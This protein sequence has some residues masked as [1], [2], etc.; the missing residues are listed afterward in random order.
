[1][2]WLK[3]YSTPHLCARYL[4]LFCALGFVLLP[5]SYVWANPAGEQVVGGAATFQ[6][7]GNKLTVNQATDRLAV[8]WQSFNIGAGESTH[9]NMPSSTSAALNRVIGGNPSSIYGSLSANGI[10]YLINPSGI[11]VGPGGTVNAASFMASTLDVSTEQFMNAKNG[12]GMN[13]YGSSGESIIN[14]GNITAEKGDVFLVAQKVENRGTINAA[15][16]TAGIVGSGQNTDVMVHEV[17]GKGFA[18]RVAQLQGE[19]ATGSN[20]DL[21]DGEELLNE[22]SINAAQAELNASG[23]VYALAIRNSGTIRAKAVVANADGTVRLDGGLGDVINTGKMYAKNAGND[24]TA[25]GGRID[26]AGQNVTASPESIITAAGGEKGGNGGSVKIDSQDTTLVQ[27]RVDVAAPSAGAKGGKVQLLGERVGLLDGAKVDAS[28]GAGGGTV[29]VGGDYLGGQTPSADLKNLAKQEAEPVKNAKATVMADTAEIKADATV[30]G[31]GGKIVLWSDEY[32]G[33][34]GDLFARGGVEGGNGGFIETSSKNNLQAMGAG[35]ASAAN[36]TGGL[37]LLDPSNLVISSLASSGGSFNSGNPNVFTPDGTVNTAVVNNGTIQNSLNA[38]TDVTLLTSGAATGTGDITMTAGISKDA[39]VSGTASTLTMIAAGSIVISQAISSVDGDLP[40]VLGAQSGVTIGAN[41]TTLGGNLTVRGATADGASLAASTTTVTMNSGTVSTLGGDGLGN[42]SITATGPVNQKG[43]TLLIKGTSSITTGGAA[44]T[45][46]QTANDFTGS[47]SLN[48]TGAN[49]VAV[50]DANTLTLGNSTIGG[51][52]GVVT[53][54]GLVAGGLNQ[55]GILTIAGISTI[56]SSVAST[57]IDLSTQANLLTGTVVIGGTASNVRDFKLRN[58]S[59]T[60]SAVTN[61][62]N[63]TTTS[64]RDFTIFYD[65]AS[66]AIP[67]LVSVLTLRNISI[68]ANGGNITQAGGIL[69]TGTATFSTSGASG[70]NID[71]SN[72]SNDFQGTVNATASNTAKNISI[73]DINDLQLGQIVLG[74]GAGNLS[75]TFGQ[76]TDTNAGLTMSETGRIQM[77]G[78]TGQLLLTPT[79]SYTDILLGVLTANANSIAVAASGITI[80]NPGNVRDLNIRNV[81]GSANFASS[82]A[83]VLPATY[84]PNLRDISLNLPNSSF[85]IPALAQSSLRNINVF[86]NGITTGAITSPNGLINLYSVGNFTITGNVNTLSGD[87]GLKSDANLTIND[88]I[89]IGASTTGN[90][91]LFADADASGAGTLSIGNTNGTGTIIGNGANNGTYRIQA[92]TLVLGAGAGANASIV[93]GSG[94]VIFAA[95]E[96]SVDIGL[97]NVVPTFNV[98]QLALNRVFSPGTVQLGDE[99]QLGNILLGSLSL[100]ANTFKTLSLVTSGAGSALLPSAGSISLRSFGINFD[101]NTNVD[102]SNSSLILD[103]TSAGFYPTGANVS[104]LK[105]VDSD[106]T[107]ATSGGELSITAG[108]AGDVVFQRSVGGINPLAV[109]SVIQ[110]NTV[111]LSRVTSRTTGL[112]GDG[113]L[114]SI[115]GDTIKLGGSI[116]LTGVTAGPGVGDAGGQLFVSGN[117]VTVN[118]TFN[119][120]GGDGVAPLTGSGNFPGGPSGEIQI[121]ALDSILVLKDP[122]ATIRGNFIALGGNPSG[123]NAGFG[124]D[125][126]V[127][128][129]SLKDIIFTTDQTASRQMEYQITAGRNLLF[130]A[131]G[132]QAGAYDPTRPLNLSGLAGGVNFI[133]NIDNTDVVRTD[134]EFNFSGRV[135]DGILYMAAGSSIRTNGGQLSI[136]DNKK[137]DVQIT[138]ANVDVTNSSYFGFGYSGTNDLY[139]SGQISGNSSDGS[140]GAVISILAAGANL[141]IDGGVIANAT[142][143]GSGGTIKIVA[144]NLETPQISANGSETITIGTTIVSPGL[145]GIVNI[146]TSG[147]SIDVQQILAKGGSTAS[148]NYTLG[149]NGGKITI[150]D[151]SSASNFDIVRVD[152]GGGD[153]TNGIGGAGGTIEF[154][155]ISLKLPQFISANG[156]SG[157]TAL[158]RGA[159]GSATFKSTAGDITFG[160]PNITVGGN[161]SLTLNSSE[162]LILGVVAQPGASPNYRNLIMNDGLSSGPLGTLTLNYGSSNGN[163]QLLMGS[164]AQISVNGGNIVIRRDNSAAVTGVNPDNGFDNG[165]MRLGSIVLSTQSGRG[166]AGTVSLYG[167][168]SGAPTP[169]KSDVI[170]LG[171]I[172]ADGSNA[173]TTEST[174]YSGGS[175][176]IDAKDVELRSVYARGGAATG[177]VDTITTAFG[178]NAGSINITAETIKLTRDLLMSGGNAAGDQNGFGGGGGNITL[179]GDVVLNSGNSSKG[180]ITLNTAGGSGFGG[181]EFGIGGQIDTRG[182]LEG[183]VSTSNTLQLIHG[184]GNVTL[185]LNSGDSI[186]IGTIITADPQGN[187]LNSTG[188]FTVY[189]SLD[190]QSLVTQGFGYNVELLGGGTIANRVTFLNTGTTRIGAAGVTTTLTDGFDALNGTTAPSTLQLGGTIK[191][192][193]A[194]TGSMLANTTVLVADTTLN[195]AGNI[196]QFGSL[197]GTYGLTLAAGVAGGNTTFSG[198]VGDTTQVG[199]ITVDSGVTGLVNFAST[200]KATGIRS[201][202]TSQLTFNNDVTLSG[203]G[204]AATDLGGTL[205]LNNAAYVDDLTA[206]LS[207]L[208]AGAKTFSG[209][210]TLSGGPIEFGGLGNYTV[211]GTIDGAQNLVLSGLGTKT[212]T[213]ILGGTTALGTGTGAA[214]SMSGGNVVFGKLTTASGIVSTA[215]VALTDTTTL[216]AGD[217]ASS[218]TGDVDLLGATLTSAGTVGLGDSAADSVKLGGAVLLNGL[219]AVNVGGT[220]TDNAGFSSFTQAETSGKISFNEDVTL[221]VANG[222]VTLNGNV[223]LSG[224]SFSTVGT[225]TL[226]NALKDSITLTTAAVTLTG[227]GTFAVNGVVVGGD[228]DLTLSGAGGKTFAGAL[229]GLGTLALTAGTGTF[230][231]TVSGVSFN[232][233][234]GV[235]VLNGNGTFTGASTLGGTSTTLN[236]ITFTAGTTDVTGALTT[237]GATTLTGGLITL[238][239]ASDVISSSGLL[240]MGSA[241]SIGQGATLNGAGAYK[242]S[243]TVNGANSLTLNGAGAK[244]FSGAVGTGTALT[245]ITQN[246]AS[247]LVT[248][249]EDVTMS[250]A[251]TFNQNLVLAGL[252]MT[253]TGSTLTF[254]NAGTDTLVISG[255]TTIQTAGKDITLNSATTLN[256]ALTMSDLAAA[257]GITTLSGAVKGKSSNLTITTDNLVVGNTVQTGSGVVSLTKKDGLAL[258]VGGV[259]PGFLNATEI[260]RISTS[261]GLTV[262]TGGDITIDQLVI[263]DTDQITGAFRMVTTGGGILVNQSV[264]LNEFSGFAAGALTAT[265]GNLSALLVTKGFRNLTLGAGGLEYFAPASMRL[266]GVEVSDDIII[267]SVNSLTVNGSVAS[268]LGNIDLGAG[269]DIQVSSRITA[270]A[271]IVVDSG[272]YFINYFTGNPFQS[273]DVRIVTSDLFASTWPSNGAVPGL[274]IV[275]GPNSIDQLSANQIGVSTT[276]LAGNAAPYIL[277]FTTGTGQPYIFAQQAAIPPVMMPA[278]LTGGN[279]FAKTISYSAD[280]IEMMTPEERSAYENQQRQVS[281]RV[282]L[283]GQSGEGEEIGAPTEGRTPQAAIP[284]VQIP[285]A[286]TAQ[287]LLEGKPLAGAKSDQERG[288]AKRILKVRPTRAVAVRS[289]FNVNEV[290]ES[291]RM[292]A[293][294]SVGSAPVVQSR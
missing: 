99:S 169:E 250:G 197:D 106:R 1:M 71:L 251:G 211:T 87:I 76:N 219:G 191:T 177:L 39:T 203:T 70:G 146:V 260:S 84:S 160:S 280:E 95:S 292:A 204:G 86:A 239:T 217:T 44:I 8:N 287:V 293:E 165:V 185:G 182:S 89:Q 105:Q 121:R 29:L 13:F 134:L 93:Q 141:K 73:Y 152:V 100:T 144:K 263:D 221:D 212:F 175:I 261:G 173:D 56:T 49:A 235:A 119:V 117:T 38:G 166:D 26:V 237:T 58:T 275:Y 98:T 96:L 130:A 284:A 184:S 90:I 193:T 18:I 113:G 65:N 64:L 257:G 120:S 59:A 27:G 116:T 225:V 178:G 216:A 276:L 206:V 21:P 155:A 35:I 53:G 41:I 180:T 244:T 273:A 190:T 286:P 214:I 247:G 28:G 94:T 252:N 131:N 63:S 227:T 236:G 267:G 136:E 274:E 69:P 222:L 74:A 32:T 176:T 104:F 272:R 164:S 265:G 68:T 12:A 288:D 40:L 57:D 51:S 126:V 128:L 107:L 188:D 72:A 179:T 233:S 101:F 79:S 162:D 145:G 194:T 122:S 3:R 82:L 135:D 170:V 278:A 167:Y 67:S 149:A 258:T 213:G 153:S 4:M 195:S 142:A 48:N 199:Q 62:G 47:V 245:T 220:V 268:R 60:A 45:L 75:L 240:T 223:G 37:W 124:D 123:G 254:G 158:N 192:V 133:T 283:Q 226:G 11:L 246:D 54:A 232:Q 262:G 207:F 256:A 285:V 208:G 7:D 181:G 154:E 97:A 20:R 186:S 189:G 42:L 150:S 25:A 148:P 224:M 92:D 9:F 282:I 243:G 14:Q 16:G 234:G 266:S 279:G 253:S 269:G 6:R 147:G 30:S 118:G 15:N 157:E 205:T 55:S 159:S 209:A 171:V 91:T 241:V 249:A 271:T 112:S 290:M 2:W 36:G 230:N 242:L 238:N 52:F 196:I 228:Q 138:L 264:Q 111:N 127:V 172:I 115:V 132:S 259:A 50:T 10:L 218:L 108:S 168:K 277:E 46:A 163:A 19:A 255:A 23:N 102:L 161:S 229:S 109:L 83:L 140:S 151:T 31:D 81:N 43:G 85:A 17:G 61:L 110:A 103:T 33:F 137:K 139:F 143:G 125:G 201:S 294:V 248:F 78:G 270:P 156:G 200:V 34:Y 5:T 183:T 22:G 291:E 24:A 215:N 202:A 289:G 66:F 281:A 174:G 129:D 80:T 114:V 77:E 198:A 231:K 210:T 187:A 88:G